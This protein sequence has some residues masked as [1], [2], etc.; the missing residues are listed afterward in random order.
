MVNFLSQLDN[1]QIKDE[2]YF[3]VLRDFRKGGLKPDNYTDF[4]R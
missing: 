3:E 1:P 2:V 4:P